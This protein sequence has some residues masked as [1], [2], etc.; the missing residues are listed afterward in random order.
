[1]AKRSHSAHQNKFD[2]ALICTGYN[3]ADPTGH[4]DDYQHHRT[5]DLGHEKFIEIASSIGILD[6]HDTIKRRNFKKFREE[7]NKLGVTLTICRDVHPDQVSY[8]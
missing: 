3:G 5:D 1:M 8:S 6:E 7:C 2:I 4:D